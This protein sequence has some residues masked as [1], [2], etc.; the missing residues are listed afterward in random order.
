MTQNAILSA[1]ALLVPAG[2]RREW[3]EE[4]TAELAFIRDESPGRA[5]AFCLGAFRD[6]F[7]IR[8][9]APPGESQNVL[10][11]SPARCLLSLAAIAA[12]AIG[13]A[14]MLPGPR[15][16][17]FEAR[18]MVEVRPIAGKFTAAEREFVARRLP[19]E[20]ERGLVNDHGLIFARLRPGVEP[21]ASLWRIAIPKDN[22]SFITVICNR[23][24]SLRPVLAM[25]W[26][27]FMAMPFVLA[28]N[29]LSRGL[30]ANVRMWLFFGAKVALGVTIAFFGIL[31][32]GAGTDTELRAHGLILGLVIALRWALKDQRRRCPVCL[33]RLT[34]PICFGEASHTFLDWYGTELICADGHG[35][36]HVPEIP[37]SSYPEPR[38][39][40]LDA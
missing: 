30:C 34:N 23:L 25:L 18:R 11:D 26:L 21:S 4:W 28:G 32:L 17:V 31:D 24:G 12:V 8:R 7:W 5:T 10:V 3:L 22:G 1:A 14:W 39:V 19:P 27:G 13:I 40:V 16:L 20:F 36:M 35:M 15:Q 37:T 6:A 33:R 9:N 38:W 29:S 2:H